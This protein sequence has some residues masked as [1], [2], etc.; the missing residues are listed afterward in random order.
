MEKKE[1][2]PL[3]ERESAAFLQAI[4]GQRYETLFTVTLFTGMRIGEIVGLTWDRGDF[5]RGLVT[6]DRQLQQA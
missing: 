5:A 6:I 3:D 2:R 4:Q 1:L